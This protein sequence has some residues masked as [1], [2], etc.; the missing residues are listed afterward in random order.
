MPQSCLMSEQFL[1]FHLELN[2][3]L[4]FPFMELIDIERRMIEFSCNYFVGV[5]HKSDFVW[6]LKADIAN[7]S[8]ADISTVINVQLHWPLVSKTQD[9]FIRYF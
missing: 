8:L 5:K 3:F 1:L 4:L 7:R 6:G 9:V 2:P